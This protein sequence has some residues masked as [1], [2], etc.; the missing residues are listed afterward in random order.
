[1]KKIPSWAGLP[2]RPPEELAKRSV[3]SAI[4]APRFRRPTTGISRS[5][6]RLRA[7]H[8][9]KGAIA[10]EVRAGSAD[11]GFSLGIREQIEN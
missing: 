2:P 7:A 3:F 5:A 11:E 8:R 10:A 6:F 1:M 9:A 4:D